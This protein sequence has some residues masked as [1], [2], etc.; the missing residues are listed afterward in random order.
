MAQGEVG[1]TLPPAVPAPGW[2]RQSF[3]ALFGVLTRG[4]AYRNLPYLMLALPLGLGYTLL[5][6]LGLILG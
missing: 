5:I 1:G 3:L 2:G 4:R 6:A